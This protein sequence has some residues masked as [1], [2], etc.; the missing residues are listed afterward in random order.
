MVTRSKAGIFKP[1]A[2]TV[3][4]P[5]F[6]P[7]SIDEALAHPDWKLAVQ[8]EYDALLTNSTWELSPLPPGRKVIGCKWLFK[9]KKNPDG[10]IERRK[11]RLVAKGCSQV[12]GC[13]FQET[14]S[15]VVKSTTIRLILS[16]AVSRGWHLWQVDINNDFL[17]GDLTDEVF[18]Q[19]PPGFVQHGSNSKKL[20][21][22]LTKALYCLR[23]APCAWFNK[24]KEFL[25]STGFVLSK[26]DAS[27]FVKVTSKFTL[28][29]IV[30]VDDIVISGSAI[31]EI[32]LFVQQL[33]NQFALKDMGNLYYFLGIKVSRS[34]SG[35]LHLCQQKYVRELLGRSSMTNAKG[36]HTPMVS[37]S[38]L[39]KDKGEPLADPIEY[40][41]L[42]G[43]LQ[44]VVLTRPNIAYAVN[45]VCQFMHEPTTVH[46]YT[47]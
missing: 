36:V 23:Q 27:L 47:L 12:P 28:Y 7:V 19:Q 35:S 41:S 29:V 30:Y 8:A 16:I 32:N 6:E 42:A 25:V 37:S 38:M 13:D 33:H 34:S 2:L 20:V 9:V 18:M 43:A 21:C 26:S 22:R 1:K 24:L 44:Y 45:Q 10:T 40:H 17:N 15:P 11:A 46:I 3:T 4:T 31:D 39:S 14:F 5:D